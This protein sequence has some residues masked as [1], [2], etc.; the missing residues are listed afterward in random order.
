MSGEYYTTMFKINMDDIKYS[1][2]RTLFFVLLIPGFL[3][4]IPGDKGV[5]IQMGSNKLT[6]AMMVHALV[7][8]CLDVLVSSYL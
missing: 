6:Q 7:Y 8:F 3:V 5:L 2:L 1:F 4:T